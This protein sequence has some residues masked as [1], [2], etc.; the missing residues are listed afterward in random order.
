VTVLARYLTDPA[1]TATTFVVIDFEGTTPAGH[2]PEPTE[3][4]AILLRLKAGAMTC[5]GR[6]TAL[7][8]PP[9]HAP[10]TAAD[11]RQT[12]ISQTMLTGRPAAGPVL[13][14]LDA[15]LS[16]PPYVTVAHHASTEA[17]ILRRY[18]HVCP[19]LAAAAMLDTLALAKTCRPGLDSYSLDGMLTQYGIAIPADRHRALADALA[20][21]EL[22]TRLLAD[23]ATRHR[24][25]Q[26]AQLRRLAGV[27]PPS[28]AT[29]QAPLF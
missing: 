3:V 21:A 24:W 16:E 14:E 18:A 29:T 10:L 15:L 5:V 25:S 20:T 27:P 12:G 28:S 1:F 17:G 23:G 2:P 26:L 8:Q 11:S 6:Y 13:A 22:L 9:A 4:G 19:T 7:I